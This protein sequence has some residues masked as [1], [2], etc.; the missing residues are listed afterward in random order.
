MSI[1]GMCKMNF[2]PEVREQLKIDLQHGELVVSVTTFQ[3][4]IIVVTDRG[5]VYEIRNL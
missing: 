5:T 2:C 4:R 3:D 1:R